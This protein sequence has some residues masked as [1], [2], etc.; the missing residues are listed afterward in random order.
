MLRRG[1]IFSFSVAS[2][3][4]CRLAITHDI[5]L[6]TYSITSIGRKKEPI[7]ENITYDESILY[8]HF[9]VSRFVARGKHPSKGGLVIAPARI[10]TATI[11]SPASLLLRRRRLY[12]NG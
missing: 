6:Y 10:H 4:L 8:E 1:G 5:R 3:F 9:F 2:R 11:I 7:A 12:N